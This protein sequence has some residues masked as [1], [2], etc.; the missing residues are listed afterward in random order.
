MEKYN[1]KYFFSLGKKKLYKECMNNLDSYK[2]C[3]IGINQNMIGSEHR[4][5]LS[6]EEL[7]QR[8]EDRKKTGS[9]KEAN[10]EE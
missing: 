5:V 4:R 2:A 9:S 6:V 8:K 3:L 7:L 10:S 1:E